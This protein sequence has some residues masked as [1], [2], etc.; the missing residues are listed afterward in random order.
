[1]PDDKRRT[2]QWRS[3]VLSR[4]SIAS[5]LERML[6]WRLSVFYQHCRVYVRRWRSRLVPY[7]RPWLEQL[8]RDPYR[9][10]VGETDRLQAQIGSSGFDATSS[11]PLLSIVLFVQDPNRKWLDETVT[12]VICQASPDWELWLC[13][14]GDAQTTRAACEQYTAQGPRIQKDPRIHIGPLLAAPNCALAFD[15][16]L[17]Q[18]RGVFIG[19]LGQH[20]Q[21]AADACAQVL[22][23]FDA[24]DYDLIYT[25]EDRLDARG[26]RYRPFF[27]PDWSPDLCLSSVYACR[28]GVYRRNLIEQAGGVC[29]PA[30][31][32][33][34]SCVA[35]D[36]LLRCV[37]QTT[38]VGHIA[39]VLYHQRDEAEGETRL[40]HAWAKRTLEAAL[41][42]REEDASVEDGPLLSTFRVR[43]RLSSSPL[44]SIIIPTRD[45]VGFLRRCVQSIES[46]TT[47][48]AYEILIVDNGSQ[49]QETLAYL[50]TLPH[51]VM[52]DDMSDAP[53]NFARVC[54]QAAIQT[55]GEQLLF[56]NN[57][58]EVITPEWLEALLEHAQR[59]EVGAVGAQLLYADQTLQHAGVVLGVRDVASHAH[60]YQPL[61]QLGYQAFP[62]LIRN[63]S[64]VT[65]ACLMLRK[66]VYEGVG[67]MNEDLA[68]TF[69]DVDLCLRLQQQGYRIVYTPYAQLYHYESKSRWYQPPRPEEVQYMR[70]HWGAVIAN[71]PYYNPHLTREREDFSFD[72]NR[73]RTWR[74]E[75]EKA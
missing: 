5:R 3:P 68:V 67:G 75:R 44:V 2:M 11:Q 23:Y 46:R 20:D 41:N 53:F 32:H 74:R 42:R 73:A 16:A 49:A 47:Y 48:P 69:N 38:R 25:D 64:A 21:L 72:I 1:M 33:A 51:N 12:S 19:L 55:R 18:T 63:Y 30:G 39:Q 36:M 9:A 6:G 59:S 70:D 66:A 37:E 52:R 58:M 35:Y 17:P 50:A 57:D 62:H 22:H 13:P 10:W 27:K 29:R 71:D 15:A 43:R 7:I 40:R 26:Q 14:I 8:R 34:D 28:F 61:S 65:A 56:L 60:K 31:M 24:Y 45:Q 54:N 4:K